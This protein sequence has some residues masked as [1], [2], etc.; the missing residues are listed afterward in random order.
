MDRHGDCLCRVC[1]GHVTFN[2]SL[3]GESESDCSHVGSGN[4]WIS[5]AKV[6]AAGEKYGRCIKAPGDVAGSHDNGIALLASRNRRH[7][8]E[9]EVPLGVRIGLLHNIEVSRAALE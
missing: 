8:V 4:D 1:G 9:A 6:A 7:I 3:R 5:C 2:V